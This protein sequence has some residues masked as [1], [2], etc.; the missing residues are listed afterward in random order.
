MVCVPL[1]VGGVCS[2]IRGWCVFHYTWVVCVPLYVGVCVP[3]YVGGVCSCM[4][5]WCVFHCTWV[6]C[7]PLYVAGYHCTVH[8]VLCTSDINAAK[9]PM[10]CFLL[11]HLGRSRPWLNK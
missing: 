10:L 6:V 8:W 11:E 9:L 4:G 2:T 1:Y 5:G 7:V 3:L